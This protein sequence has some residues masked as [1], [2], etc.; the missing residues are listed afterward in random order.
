M[1]KNIDSK[2]QNT[3]NENSHKVFE[4]CQDYDKTLDVPDF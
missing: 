3:I 2:I 4:L 1:I